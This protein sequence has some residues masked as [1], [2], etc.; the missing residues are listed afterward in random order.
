MEFEGQYL[1]YED[2]RLLG[3]TLDLTPFNILEFEARRII[4]TRT[5]NRLKDLEYSEIP[6]EVKLCMLSMINNI[7]NYKTTLTNA[8]NNNISSENIDGYNVSYLNATSISDIIK[9]KKYEF[10][11]IMN[12][13]LIGVV[14]NGEHIMYLGVR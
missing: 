13:Y 3:G 8:S 9:S 1:T 12:N 7:T 5:Q 6:Q 4:D 14:V 10:E 2:Y 11:D